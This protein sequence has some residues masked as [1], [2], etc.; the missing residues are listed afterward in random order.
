VL[1]P[2]RRMTRKQSAKHAAL[3]GKGVPP[4]VAKKIV[5]AKKTKKR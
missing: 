3:I 2:K 1:T 4:H 5:G